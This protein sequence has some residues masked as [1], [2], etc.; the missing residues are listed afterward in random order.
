PHPR[1]DN[2]LPVR[3]CR[4]PHAFH[5]LLLRLPHESTLFP[6]TPLFRSHVDVPAQRTDSRE[7]HEQHHPAPTPAPWRLSGCLRRNGL[8]HH[9]KSIIVF[10][11]PTSSPAPIPRLGLKQPESERYV[12]AVSP[13]SPSTF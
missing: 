5:F 3:A 2:H 13:L 12:S 4:H 10:G 7:Q 11:T 8:R 9:G 1:I 6:L